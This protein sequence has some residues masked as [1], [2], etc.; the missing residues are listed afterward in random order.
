MRPGIK[1]IKQGIVMRND[2]RCRQKLVI[3]G[4]VSVAYQSDIV[5]H[6][7][8][9]S[10]RSIDAVFGHAACDDEMLDASRFK[11][12]LKRCLKER[13]RRA[14]ADDQVSFVRLDIGV[15]LPAFR[16][17]LKRMT[18]VAIVLNVDDQDARR[19]RFGKQL[20]DLL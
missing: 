17:N 9:S 19:T 5:A 18:S 6:A 4:S 14:F 11:L 3:H 2:L 8:R 10:R 20:I 15:N 7:Y 16:A 13:I 1:A 12:A